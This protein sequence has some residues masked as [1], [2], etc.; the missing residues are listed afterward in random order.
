[1]DV[2]FSIL[3]SLKT[4]LNSFEMNSP[5]LADQNTLILCSNCI[6]TRA[7]NSFNLSNHF[8]FVFNMYTHTLLDKLSIEV[9]KYL[10]SSMDMVLMVPHTSE[11]TISKDLVNHVPLLLRNDALY[12]LP[13]M[14][15]S[16]TNKNVGRGIL[17]I[18]IPLIML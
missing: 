4:R 5:P 18:F 9:T 3:C 7:L 13:S 16:Q 6:L 12:C 15:V 10:V 2:S 11:C 17:P 14:H 1:M 8:C